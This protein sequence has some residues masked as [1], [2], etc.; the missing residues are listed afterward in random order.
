MEVNL[1]T[2]LVG[3]Q[4][5]IYT[6]AIDIQNQRL[7]SAGN[8]KGIVE[9]DLKEGTFTRVLCNVASSVYC[10]CFIEQANYL[11]AGLRNG[12]I[13]VID[14]ERSEL[15]TRLKVEKGAVFAIQYLPL[16]NELLAIGE[17]GKAYV[18]DFTFF[19]LLYQFE[20]SKTTVR[21]LALSPDAKVLAF[22][23]KEGY[24][25]LHDAND[26]HQ[27]A[28]EKIHDTGV[29]SLAYVGDYL[30]SGGR[31]AKLYKFIPGTLQVEHGIVPHMF[32]IYGILPLNSEMFSTVSRD[33][34]IKIWNK[35]MKLQKNI[36][37]DKGIESHFLSINTQG[38]DPSQQLIATAGDDK[39]I[40]LWQLS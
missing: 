17:M 11:I 10:L 28:R 21:S 22:G 37:R 4:N 27:I 20:V 7:F 26:F 6:I 13:L 39:L 31:D 15:K 8:D 18:W 19:E 40:K 5:P 23:D 1:S 29:S 32:T 30:F 9:W 24:V 33:K 35:E 3:H 34:T 2:T 12:D 36:S 16:K 38:F 25:A 14:L